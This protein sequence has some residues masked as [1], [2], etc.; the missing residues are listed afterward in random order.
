MGG[1]RGRWISRRR[2]RR[3]APSRRE[4]R[5]SLFLLRT[6][7]YTRIC[8]QDRIGAH[9][10]AH[11]TIAGL[12]ASSRASFGLMH[13]RSPSAL[14]RIPLHSPLYGGV[15]REGLPT[16]YFSLSLWCTRNWSPFL[17]VKPPRT[18]ELVLRALLAGGKSRAG[19]LAIRYNDPWNSSLDEKTAASKHFDRVCACLSF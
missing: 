2:R 18:I 12:R 4:P 19:T 3:S 5:C 7:W 6:D 8:A 17:Y 15:Y 14:D 9:E 11:E 10:Y 1:Q 13:I 16:C